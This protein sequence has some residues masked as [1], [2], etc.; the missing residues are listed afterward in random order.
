MPFDVERNPRGVEV[1]Q[2]QKLFATWRREFPSSPAVGTICAVCRPR[3]R[4]ARRPRNLSPACGRWLIQATQRPGGV[5]GAFDWQRQVDSL[6]EMLDLP[7][8][9]K[10]RVA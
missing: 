2:P 5:G 4:C 3:S 7:G 6:L 10:Q 9:T 8:G 1:L